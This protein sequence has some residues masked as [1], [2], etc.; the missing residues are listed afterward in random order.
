MLAAEVKE[1][2]SMS[3]SSYMDA[4]VAEGIVECLS[5]LLKAVSPQHSSLLVG[6]SKPLHDYCFLES[7][8][9]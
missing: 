9:L 8:S 7:T 1:V 3:E 5:P 2:V 6:F 4:E